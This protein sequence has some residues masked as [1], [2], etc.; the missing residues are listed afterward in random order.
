MGFF[1]TEP[2]TD[3]QPSAEKRFQAASSTIH[4]KLVEMIDISKLGHW[5]PERLQREIET[6]HGR[7]IEGIGPVREWTEKR[8]SIACRP[9]SCLK[10]SASVRSTN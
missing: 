1:L 10:C 3:E 2:A 5:K 9:S 8:Q 6:A 7:Q 4:N